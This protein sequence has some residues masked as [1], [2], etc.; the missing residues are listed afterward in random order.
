MFILFIF[1]MEI[2]TNHHSNQGRLLVEFP[3]FFPMT[4]F[5]LPRKKREGE[6]KKYKRVCTYLRS[7]K[8]QIHV[9]ETRRSEKRSQ[10]KLFGNIINAF[11]YS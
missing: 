8:N 3:P 11:F 9:D 6:K 4:T 5:F 2:T 1:R 10:H 7:R